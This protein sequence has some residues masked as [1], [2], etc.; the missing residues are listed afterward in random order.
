MLRLLELFMRAGGAMIGF[1]RTGVLAS[2]VLGMLAWRGGGVTFVELLKFVPELRGSLPFH[3]ETCPPILYWHGLSEDGI[4][5]IRSAVDD[6]LVQ[7]LPASPLVYVLDGH[8][9]HIP[10]AAERKSYREI[11]WLPVTFA[12]TEAGAETAAR[13]GL[14][15]AANARL[16]RQ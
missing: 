7:L 1:Q 2:D 4:A 9:S 3:D 14:V 10:L 8:V 6:G 13:E 5:A 16:F 12:V 15:M 11:R